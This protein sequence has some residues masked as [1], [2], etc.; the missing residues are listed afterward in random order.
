MSP[1]VSDV[2]ETTEQPKSLKGITAIPDSDDDEDDEPPDVPAMQNGDMQITPSNSYSAKDSMLLAATKPA[3]MEGVFE[4]HPTLGEVSKAATLKQRQRREVVTFPQSSSHGNSEKGNTT[5]HEVSSSPTKAAIAPPTKKNSGARS[6]AKDEFAED[7]V[8]AEPTSSP[9]KSQEPTRSNVKIL[10]RPVASTKEE[11]SQ[12]S[13]IPS[14]PLGPIKGGSF[15]TKRKES[16][17]ASFPA[18]EASQTKDVV[19]AE[20]KAMKI[21]SP[22]SLIIYLLHILDYLSYSSSLSL[23]AHHWRAPISATPFR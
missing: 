17:S 10:E 11:S 20:L 9:P 16:P 6:T 12:A 22:L 23:P 7:K 4:G 14:S 18:P 1:T 8:A 13:D 19:M 2:T 21:V 5:S 3:A 15:K